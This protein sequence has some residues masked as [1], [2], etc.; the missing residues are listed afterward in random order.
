MKRSNVF[1]RCLQKRNLRTDADVQTLEDAAALVFLDHHLE[2]FR[3]RDDIGEEKVIEIIR[4]TWNKMTERATRRPPPWS[5]RRRRP[6]W[7]RRR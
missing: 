4:K 2:D 5:S 7:W 6:G 1:G 3:K